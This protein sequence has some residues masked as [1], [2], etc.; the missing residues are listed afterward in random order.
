[1]LAESKESAVSLGKEKGFKREYCSPTLLLT[2]F[3]FFG[4]SRVVKGF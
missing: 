3:S 1:M 4:A 2:S